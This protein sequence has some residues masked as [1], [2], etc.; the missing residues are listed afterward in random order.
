M[1]RARV[2]L[3]RSFTSRSILSALRLPLRHP[4]KYGAEGGSRTLMPLLAGVFETPAAASYATSAIWCWERESNPHGINPSA[5][6]T[7]AAAYYAI[8]A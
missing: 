3:A 6:K 2:E 4:G 8:P 1:P 5:S 7:D